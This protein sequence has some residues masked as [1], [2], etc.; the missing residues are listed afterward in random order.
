MT[1]F[2]ELDEK[3]LTAKFFLRQFKEKNLKL[4]TETSDSISRFFHFLGTKKKS[5][6]PGLVT[7]LFYQEPDGAQSSAKA[8][9]VPES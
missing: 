1:P 4:K 8:R 7:F 9:K 2:S 3:K 5:T 6:G